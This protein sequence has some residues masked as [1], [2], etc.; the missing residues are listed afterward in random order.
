[1]ILYIY[2]DRPCL[3]VARKIPISEER[4]LRT[5]SRGCCAICTKDLVGGGLGAE[6]NLSEMAHIRGVAPGSKR[7]DPSMDADAVNKHT[8]LILLCRDCHKIVDGKDSEY[9]VD[10]LE[11]VKSKFE[12]WAKRQL[13][14]DLRGTSFAELEVV[15]KWVASAPA[16]KPERVYTVT[17]PLKKIRKNGL[18][19]T[20]QAWIEMGMS[21]SHLVGK[22]V[23][24]Q[25]DPEFGE[26]LKEGFRAIYRRLR[27]EEGLDGEDTFFRIL[28][29]DAVLPGVGNRT[30]AVIVLVYLF[31]KCEVFER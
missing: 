15:A 26:R 4:I 18:S 21:K 7:H 1:M 24:A 19:R 27:E 10:M 28:D 3:S 6:S 17:A 22:Y 8:N 12:A 30:P 25:P 20:A 2:A 13:V 14:K 29:M 9:T 5:R 23:E 11:E 31:E 16:P